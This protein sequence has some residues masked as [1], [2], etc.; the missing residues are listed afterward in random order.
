MPFAQRRLILLPISL[1]YGRRCL[2]L[3]AT[4]RPRGLPL[5]QLMLDHPSFLAIAL[6]VIVPLV[7]RRHKNLCLRLVDPEALMA[8]TSNRIAPLVV[9]SQRSKSTSLRDAGEEVWRP[10]R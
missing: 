7:I 5:I 9:V 2:I 4:P 3:A 1:V 6:P 8:L 10:R